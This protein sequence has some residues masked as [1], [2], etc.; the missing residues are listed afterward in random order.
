MKKQPFSVNTLYCQTQQNF[1]Q[2]LDYIDKE[3]NYDVNLILENIVRIHNIA[4]LQQTLHLQ[5][6]ISNEEEKNLNVSIAIVVFLAYKE[7]S[8]YVLEYLKKINRNFSINIFAENE[9]F[10]KTISNIITHVKRLMKRHS[11]NY[12]WS[13]KNMIMYVYC[14]I[15][16]SPQKSNL[17]VLE[18]HIFIMFGK[19]C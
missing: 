4:D 10:W 7:S 14:M 5:Y 11:Q 18:N 17:A 8:E 1:K 2:A 9:E 12:F 6:I 3:T 15:Q 13:L 16:T 19:I